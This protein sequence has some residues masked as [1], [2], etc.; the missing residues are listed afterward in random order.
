MNKHSRQQPGEHAVNWDGRDS[1]GR[2]VPPGVYFYHLQTAV[3]S[4][5]RRAI[6]VR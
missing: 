5:T 3:G 1:R 4:D 6:L 2:V